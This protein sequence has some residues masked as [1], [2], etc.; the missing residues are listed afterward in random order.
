MSLLFIIVYFR[1]VFFKGCTGLKEQCNQRFAVWTRSCLQGK[2]FFFFLFSLTWVEDSRRC[3]QTKPLSMK[4]LCGRNSTKQPNGSIWLW[5][6]QWHDRFGWY[7]W[8]ILQQWLYFLS[9]RDDFAKH[10]VFTTVQLWWEKYFKNVFSQ[11][12]YLTS[13]QT[14]K[15][16]RSEDARRLHETNIDNI[17]VYQLFLF[18]T[19]YWILSYTVNSDLHS[20][21][22]LI[23]TSSEHTKR[24]SSHSVFRR[25]NSDLSL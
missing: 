10:Y 4:V 24:S 13:F 23:T 8:Y 14:R 17:V 2:Y 21:C 6:N 19:F 25:K 1:G 16:A 20:F 3:D 15:P 22:R 9:L 18:R 12:V 11:L 7:Q 5:R